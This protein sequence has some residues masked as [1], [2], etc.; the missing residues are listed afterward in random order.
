MKKK[1]NKNKQAKKT[2]KRGKEKKTENLIKKELP[3]TK[4][5]LREIIQKEEGPLKLG[6]LY[7]SL[8]KKEEIGTEIAEKII[9]R[10]LKEIEKEEKKN[11]T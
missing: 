1:I 10:S 5:K 3:E 8:I 7:N 9:D 6:K 4:K 11:K 2:G